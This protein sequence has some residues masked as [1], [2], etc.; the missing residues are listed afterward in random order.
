MIAI[1]LISSWSVFSCREQ[2]LFRTRGEQGRT[3]GEQGLYFEMLRRLNLWLFRGCRTEVEARN[4]RVLVNSLWTGRSIIGLSPVTL[5]GHCSV[6]FQSISKTKMSLE[7]SFP[8]LNEHVLLLW[9]KR[10]NSVRWSLPTHRF[11]DW[12]KT[13]AA[14]KFKRQTGNPNYERH[15]LHWRHWLGESMKWSAEIENVFF[16]FSTW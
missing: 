14:L 6:I 1:T 3:C 2:S 9:I 7:R 16:L 8:A 13:E 4:E 15:A 10:P 11:R 12:L 5:D